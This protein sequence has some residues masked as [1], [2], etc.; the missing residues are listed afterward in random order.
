MHER[1]P[2]PTVTFLLTEI[3]TGLTL[4]GI[5][6]GAGQDAEGRDRNRR[7]AQLAYD[8]IVKFLPRMKLTVDESGK[9][10]T[11]LERLRAAIAAIPG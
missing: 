1:R 6:T 4:A 8:T 7:N 10:T 9:I 2:D 11:G 5:A 3:E